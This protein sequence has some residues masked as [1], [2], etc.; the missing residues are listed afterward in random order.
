MIL[1][2][3]THQLYMVMWICRLLANFCLTRPLTPTMFKTLSLKNRFF[4][5]TLRCFSCKYNYS[6]TFLLWFGVWCLVLILI[7]LFPSFF[8]VS[9]CFFS[10][11]CACVFIFN[12]SVVKGH[13]I[14]TNNVPPLTTT[15]QYTSSKRTTD[16]KHCSLNLHAS[17]K[18]SLFTFLSFMLLKIL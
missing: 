1:T 6:Q 17:I 9:F 2:C 11:A 14:E 5:D 4:H 10:F 8:F 15:Y 16:G 7:C 13:H 12:H 18:P 3:I